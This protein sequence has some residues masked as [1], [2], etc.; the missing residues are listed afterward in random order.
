MSIS[1]PQF[2]KADGTYGTGQDQPCSVSGSRVERCE[3]TRRP[4][5]VPCLH[6]SIKDQ[7]DSK[8]HTE[9][10]PSHE[11]A[12][13]IEAEVGLYINSI[14]HTEKT[15]TY[16][17][18]CSGPFSCPTNPCSDVKNE[19]DANHSTGDRYDDEGEGFLEREEEIKTPVLLI[20]G[21]NTCPEEPARCFS[22]TSRASPTSTT[23]M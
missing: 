23:M 10:H 1:T 16:S 11:H 19:Y 4:G 22:S 7:R 17:V 13:D 5:R 9:R 18:E 8:S 12:D 6:V 20:S 15:I 3:I 21:I 14:D 2:R